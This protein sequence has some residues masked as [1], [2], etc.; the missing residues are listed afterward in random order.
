MSEICEPFGPNYPDLPAVKKHR[1]PLASLSR[2]Q[3]R[4]YGEAV[5]TAIRKLQRAALQRELPEHRCNCASGTNHN[6]G[7]AI[8]AAMRAKHRAA[9]LAAPSQERR[10]RTPRQW[11]AMYA[12]AME[13]KRAREALPLA[14]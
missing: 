5:E 10:A 8:S 2:D 12:E 3:R 14:A 4:A 13:A 9:L 6:D 7:A 1:K 11:E